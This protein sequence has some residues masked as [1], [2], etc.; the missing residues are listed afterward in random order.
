[1]GRISDVIPVSQ[2]GPIVE[3]AL[4][5]PAEHASQEAMRLLCL[6]AQGCLDD[7]VS[8]STGVKDEQP[9]T[10]ANAADDD[11]A[12]PMANGGQSAAHVSAEREIRAEL[13]GQGAV[14]A[15]LHHYRSFPQP[16]AP[17]GVHKP[18]GITREEVAR[19]LCWLCEDRKIYAQLSDTG[20]L[21]V[22]VDLLRGG[23]GHEKR[24]A[25]MTVVWLTPVAYAQL[26]TLGAV[27]A[28]AQQV[29]VCQ[30]ACMAVN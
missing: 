6:L 15:A 12:A 11:N 16:P 2:L 5:S 7:R 21:E 27:T 8:T 13:V 14:K 10:S 19:F 24:A 18:S 20:A 25:T 22:L 26:R 29:Q 9:A 23:Q 28:L 4:T 1:M 30:N 3:I 17:G